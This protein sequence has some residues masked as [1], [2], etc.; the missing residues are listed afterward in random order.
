V[1]G[2]PASADAPNGCGP[3]AA[4]APRRP[5][6]GRGR[7]LSWLPGWCGPLVAA[8]AVAG[9]AAE[10]RR[11]ASTA[12][13]EALIT[14]LGSPDFA[15][16]E[17]ATA[18]LAELGGAA[19]DALLTAA[20]V[21]ADLEVALRA[22][23]LAESLPLVEP[24]DPPEA[25]ALLER[26][27]R[28]SYA[29]RVRIM[30]DLLRLDGD[31]GIE[32]LARI[33]RLER[34]AAGSR[35][36]AA[37]L[38]KEWGPDEPYWP[39]LVPRI[40]A[41]LGA[42]PRPAARL[43][44]ALCEWS[45]ADGAAAAGPLDEAVAAGAQLVAGGEAAGELIGHLGDESVGLAWTGPIFRRC[46]AEMLARGGRREA[47]LEEARSL[48]AD[49]WKADDEGMEAAIELDRLAAGGLP[50]AADEDPGRPAADVPFYTYAVAAV[51]Q[52]QGKE[53]AAAEL[54]DVARAALAR[55]GDGT[56]RLRAALLLNRLGADAWAE[57]EYRDL[58]GNPDAP[59]NARMLAAILCA[60]L[61]HDH[62]RHTEAADVLRAELEP[63]G[64]RRA[65]VERI[66]EQMDRDPRATRSR[67][68][69]FAA[70][71]TA[72]AAERRG[73]LEES[74]R[75][76]SRDVDTL[77]ALY[78]LPDHTPKQRAE[79]AARVARGLEGIE[80]EI[81]S[82]PAEANG[83]NEYAWLA[84]NTEGDLAKATRYSRRSLDLSF[85]SSS[86]LDTLAHCHAASGA[87][88][89]AVRTQWLA[90]RRDPYNRTILRNLDRFRALAAAE[91]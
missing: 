26:F 84:A 60:E 52:R 35:I 62:E 27:A 40:L 70:R 49:A 17:E 69:Y 21:S 22:R 29:D 5:T 72:D 53:A 66:L 83:Y 77:I 19:A 2:S 11:P 68:L 51:R 87:T 14:A 9:F 59:G 18:R 86:Y 50:E 16:R 23:W 56:D 63:P 90:H 73:L 88:E 64:R 30:H 82:D 38:V 13:L 44:R 20:E 8:W 39:G 31:A 28:A 41:G 34:T 48:L 89:L 76:D 1:N 75:S 10:D 6:A 54:A 37:L 58:L 80:E 7:T 91:P 43:L 32:P 3:K 61:L 65:E 85:D 67:M 36:A 46:V 4:R 71:G 47:A 25:A 81:A 55:A 33:V 57:R 42:T 74:L 78:R 79:A 12:E 45:R 15:V 24:H